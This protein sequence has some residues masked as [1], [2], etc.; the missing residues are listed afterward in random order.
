MNILQIM[1]KSKYFYLNSSLI[2]EIFEFDPTFHEIFSEKVLPQIEL[3]ESK[4]MY[5]VF[6]ENW[7]ET[8]IKSFRLSNNHF[9][10]VIKD[11][12]SYWGDNFCIVQWEKLENKKI[13][14]IIYNH[15]QC[16]NDYIVVKL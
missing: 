10:I 12:H 6:I 13:K 15:N 2:K 16:L 1:S 11:N 3:Y 9:T 5:K 7:M 8:T 14:F 4:K